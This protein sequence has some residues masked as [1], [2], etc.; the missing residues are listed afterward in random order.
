MSKERKDCLHER[1]VII[2]K[3]E[4]YNVKGEDIKV[5]AHVR[6]CLD[7]NEE[8][9]DM[10]LD[11]DN[12]KQAY[13]IYRKKHNMLSTKDII[14]LR[15]KYNLSQRT[16]AILI[17]CT[18]ATVVRYEK[19]ALQNLTYDNIMKMLEEPAN[20][21]SALEKNKDKLDAKEVEKI[22]MTL[23]DLLKEEKCISSYEKFLATLPLK[24]DNYSN[25]QSDFLNSLNTL[26][27]KNDLEENMQMVFVNKEEEV[28]LKNLE[29]IFKLLN[30]MGKTLKITSL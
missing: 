2:E 11:T 10:V 19:G 25:V 5:N 3:E 23:N 7:C 26:F 6:K 1:T 18:Q 21:K 20:L 15:R 8:I 24:D 12:L 27:E 4:I 28:L 13:D 14:N 30:A 29:E 16:F 22:E 9:L 17:G